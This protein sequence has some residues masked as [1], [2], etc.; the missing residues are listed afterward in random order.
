MVAV[1]EPIQPDYRI[2]VS[3]IDKSREYYLAQGY[4]NPYRWARHQDAPFVRLERPLAEARVGLVTTASLIES[5]A[6][7]EPFSVPAIV[8]AAP[9]D[10][11]PARLY[12]MHRFWDQVA[13]HTDDLNSYAP[14]Q[15]LQEAAANGRIGRVSPRF[16]GVPTVYSQRKTNEADAP[17]LLRLCLE[18]A[19]DAAILVAL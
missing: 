6:A 16:Y 19:V 3:Y 8:Y 17:G 15:R 1:T 13:T 5:E 7:P 10:P 12:T 14:I 4:R 18:D 9:V 11:P 2:F